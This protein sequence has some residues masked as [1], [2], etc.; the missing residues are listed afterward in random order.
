MDSSECPAR[1]FG[2][3]A[4]GD[5][6]NWRSVYTLLNVFADFNPVLPEPYRDTPFLFLANIQPQLQTRVLDQV[7]A[8]KL[9]GA[10]TMNFWIEGAPDALRD[11]IERVDILTINDS[12]ARQLAGEYNLVKAARLI[13]QM[14]PRV[15]VIKR[16]EYGVLMAREDGSF[17]TAP[18]L[19]LDTVIDPTGA[20]DTFA[21]GFMGY[22]ASCGEISK[23]NMARA[24][25][26][27]SALASFAVQD[28]SLDR[29]LRLTRAEIEDRYQQFRQLTQF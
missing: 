10:D 20:G 29:L 23:A 3:R 2:G 25:I 18:A 27:G 22:L 28:F 16:G 12:E 1:R 4:Y 13:R 24:A 6:L 21:G 9:V 8:P 15:L 17:F 5:D 26:Y 11:V 19:P 7:R 14:G